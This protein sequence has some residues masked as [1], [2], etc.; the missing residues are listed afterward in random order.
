MGH[1]GAEKAVALCGHCPATM[2]TS[3]NYPVYDTNPK[4]SPI[5][6]TEKTMNCPSPKQHT[7]MFAL[8]PSA[9]I[10]GFLCESVMAEKQPAVVAT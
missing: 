3:P 6:A 1:G 4:H 9:F 8:S 2:K 10:N 7:E 5:P